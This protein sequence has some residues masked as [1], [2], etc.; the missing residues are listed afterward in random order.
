MNETTEATRTFKWEGS[1]TRLPDGHTIIET[2]DGPDHTPAWAIFDE[3]GPS[4]ETSDD[5][6][7]WLDVTRCLNANRLVI[8]LTD[9][10]GNRS[11][12]TITDVPTLLWLSQHFR[13]TIEDDTRFHYYNVR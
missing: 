2:H 7:L 6:I 11:R 5:G 13:W 12:F 3:S 1:G 4:P 10:K 8:P 9:A